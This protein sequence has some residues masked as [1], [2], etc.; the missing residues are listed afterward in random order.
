M[1]NQP[2][3]SPESPEFGRLLESH[4]QRILHFILRQVEN[5]ADAEDLLQETFLQAHRSIASFQGNAAFSTWLGGIA[6]NLVRNHINRSPQWRYN[7]VD[8]EALLE[9]AEHNDSALSQAELQLMLEQMQTELQTLATPLREA[10]L[11]V[12]VHNMTYQEVAAVQ[13]T[14]VA[15]IKNRV[16]RARSILRERLLVEQS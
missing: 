9:L 14:T 11:M 3:Y 2:S 16:F 12:A 10:L 8:T 15:N 1:Q 7:F 6:L 4:R 13:Q 5:R